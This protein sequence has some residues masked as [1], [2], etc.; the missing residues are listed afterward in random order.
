MDSLLRPVSQMRILHVNHSD[1]IGG[2]ARAAFRIHRSQVAAGIASRMRVIQRI[3]DDSLVQGGA[4][5]GSG[6]ISQRFRKLMARL[7]MHGFHTTNPIIHSAAWPD[8]RL[9]RELNASDADILNLHWL[10]PNTLSVAEVGHL[11]KPVVWTLHDMWAFCGAEHYGGDGQNA[12]FR[13]GYRQ[14]NCPPEERRKDLNRSVWSRKRR[15]W[16]KPMH[17]VCPSRWL[18]DCARESVLF[19]DWPIEVI[20]NPIDSDQWHPVPKAVA[21]AALG[22]DPTARLVLLGAPGGLTDPRKGGDLALDALTRIAS[23]PSA[24]DGLVIFGQSEAAKHAALPLPTHFLG[25]LQDDLS[26]ILAYSAAD[27]FVVPSRQDNLP[28][29]AI[30][31]LA[32]GTPVVAFNIGGLPDIITHEQTGWLA[33]P[34][35]T[36]NLA[37]GIRW[38]LAAPKRYARLCE[39]ARLDAVQRFAYPVVAEC[40]RKL[41]EQ[42]L[43]ADERKECQT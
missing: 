42:V 40:Y 38:V 24:P 33:A 20:P 10:G 17:I 11:T 12:R 15:H 19:G 6:P 28:N 43:A 16:R 26:L 3:G 35:D 14:D 8:S 41:Y 36:E 2:A 9:G 37:Q 31:S 18:I 22:L 4:A 23:G 29:T 21:R 34:F 39:Q 30:E 25:R 7:L 27:V 13:V 1:M 32:C 5:S